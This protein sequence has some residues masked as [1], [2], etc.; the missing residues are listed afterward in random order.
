MECCSY[1]PSKQPFIPS[2][3]T[4]E[5]VNEA[6]MAGV[7]FFLGGGAGFRRPLCK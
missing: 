7:V 4:P 3:I 1:S 2:I 5:G 6:C